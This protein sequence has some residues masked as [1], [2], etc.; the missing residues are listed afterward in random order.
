MNKHKR[1]QFTRN[2]RVRKSNPRITTRNV[3]VRKSNP[4]ITTRNVRVRKSNPRITTRNVR[5]RKSTLKKNIKHK[6]NNTRKKVGGFFG[7]FKKKENTN[8]NEI[9]KY[10]LKQKNTTQ[11]NSIFNKLFK[12]KPP[13]PNSTKPPASSTDPLESS[14]TPPTDPLESS[15]DPLESS[16][17]PLESSTELL[18]SS[19]TEPKKPRPPPLP[20]SERPYLKPDVNINEIDIQISPLE[21]YSLTPDLI[22]FG[23]D[24]KYETLLDQTNNIFN[25]ILDIKGIGGNTQLK[26]TNNYNDIYD[27]HYYYLFILRY[28]PSDST[29]VFLQRILTKRFKRDKS[30]PEETIK[31]DTDYENKL[32]RR[33]NIQERDHMAVSPITGTNTIKVYISFLKGNEDNNFTTRPET[34]IDIYN[35][36]YYILNKQLYM[37]NE[38]LN[39]DEKYTINCRQLKEYKSFEEFMGE[40]TE[41]IEETRKPE[42]TAY[43]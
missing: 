39:N 38:K 23:I 31:I 6:L 13:D 43:I 24:F 14:T 4:R 27:Y 40:E 18:E 37:Q 36:F 16:T 1:P 28:D 12:K 25:K 5:V 26:I 21:E 8:L 9:P 15:T 33:C 2:V 30:T 10:T 29:R 32:S 19:S 3:R 41:E 7:L 20:T 11:P 34:I 17:D 22:T 42:A 35:T